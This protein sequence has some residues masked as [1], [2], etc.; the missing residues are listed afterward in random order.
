MKK[1]QKIIQSHALLWYVPVYLELDLSLTF[2]SVEYF[3][4][5]STVMSTLFVPEFKL[6]TRICMLSVS[7]GEQNGGT[8]R[9]IWS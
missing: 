4:L 1:V 3:V 6:K 9:R 8:E 7:P 2:G 5:S